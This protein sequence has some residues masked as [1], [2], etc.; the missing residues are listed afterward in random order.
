MPYYFVADNAFPLSR[1]VLR[2][3][4]MSRITNE[5]R[6]FNYRL[7]RARKTIECAFGMMT[8]KFQVFLT[9]IRSS[10]YATI[11]NVV[12]SACVLHNFIR[13]KEGRPYY[14]TD[15]ENP[16]QTRLFNFTQDLI[17]VNPTSS[18]PIVRKYLTNY[19][20]TPQGALS[21]QSNHCV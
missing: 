20:I 13:L 12:K 6:I 17:N 8:Q 15:F 9:P 18:G 5:K 14:P 19:F 11:N 16:R 21:W 7:S 4:P 10:S 1:R 2:P 3:Y